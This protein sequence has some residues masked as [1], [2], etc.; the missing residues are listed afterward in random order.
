MVN[1]GLECEEV[2]GWA[3]CQDRRMRAEVQREGSGKVGFRAVFRV[4]GR[5]GGGLSGT[6][7]L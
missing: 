2:R 6:P 5:D 4:W 3:G 7:R 1:Y